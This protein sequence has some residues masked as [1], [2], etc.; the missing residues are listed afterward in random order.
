MS[1]REIVV[2]KSERGWSE[3]AHFTN[4]RRWLGKKIQFQ[5]PQILYARN[6]KSL[7]ISFEFCGKKR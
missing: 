4:G 5:A 1:A 2:Y 7:L 6:W 3:H